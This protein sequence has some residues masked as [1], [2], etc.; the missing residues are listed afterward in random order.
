MGLLEDSRGGNTN[1]ISIKQQRGLL[2][3]AVHMFLVFHKPGTVG[4]PVKKKKI[5]KIK[6]IFAPKGGLNSD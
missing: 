1:M 4:P 2:N 6:K 5:K 3:I